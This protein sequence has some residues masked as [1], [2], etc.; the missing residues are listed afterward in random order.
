MISPTSSALSASGFSHKTCLPAARDCSTASRCKWLGRQMSTA[1]TSSMARSSSRERTAWRTSVRSRSAR[2]FGASASHSATSL[3]LR[4]RR[5]AGRCAT[6]ATAPHP[7]KPTR[8]GS[9]A[10][11]MDPYPRE[12]RRIRRKLRLCGGR[13]SPQGVQN[14]EDRG[15][16]GVASEAYRACTPQRSATSATKRFDIFNGLLEFGLDLLDKRVYK[17]LFRNRVL[18]LALDVEEP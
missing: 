12:Q 8:T 5:Y 16:R 18:L 9:F 11:F 3:T 14:G 7:T 1:S 4:S 10:R 6:C 17:L 2:S 13:K 15:A